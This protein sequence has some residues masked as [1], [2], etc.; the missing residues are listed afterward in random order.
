[1]VLLPVVLPLMLL[2]RVVLVLVLPVVVAV[3]EVVVVVVEVVLVVVEVVLFLK[4][5]L[6][7]LPLLWGV[8]LSLAFLVSVVP[9]RMTS[10]S[11]IRQLL[12]LFYL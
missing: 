2:L 7:D 1:V 11:E 4:R 12:H 5:I 6:R 3:V 10:R 9:L 8:S